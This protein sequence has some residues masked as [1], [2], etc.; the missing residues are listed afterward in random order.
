MAEEEKKQEEQVVSQQQE[1]PAKTED[2]P[3]EKP[4]DAVPAKP[5]EGTQDKRPSG[6]G[7]RPN[8]GQRGGGSGG[9]RPQ[10]GRDNRGGR[11]GPRRE[12]SREEK[13]AAWDPITKLGNQVKEGKVT[14]M[15]DA[16][17]SGLPLREVQIVDHL[18]PELEDEV[19]DVNMVQRMTDSGRRV[20][21][22]ITTVV[23]NNDG[24]VGVGV[25]KGKEVG[26]AIRKAIDHAKLNILE[27]RRGCGSWECGCKEPHSFPFQIKGK[28]SSVE[29]ILKP[30]PKG[31]YL[32]VSD[33]PRKILKL[34]GVKDCWA[35][36][37]GQTRTTLNYSKAV[38]DALK[39]LNR[40]KVTKT[41]MDE[42]KIAEGQLG[43]GI[44]E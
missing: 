41:Q 23:G 32:A 33:V 3:A 42:F 28:C 7:Y 39:Q 8:Q 34:A 5:K 31:V 26:P 13:L 2:T 10:G 15:H 22:A 27:V 24:Y 4:Q 9:R 1:T 17:N 37:S 20:R 44:E 18:L 36:T 43:G 38:F 6:G 21:F 14:T 30:A 29:I 40:T 19:L 35:I 25:A 11:G 12:P 16:L